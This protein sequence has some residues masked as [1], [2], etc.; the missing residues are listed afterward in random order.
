MPPYFNF[1]PILD[2]SNNRLNTVNN[3]ND[4][5][6]SDKSKH[7]EKIDDINCKFECNKDGKY[8]WRPFQ[9]I[10]P[11]MYINLVN[12][13]TEQDNW[14]LLKKRFR[15]FK[16]NQGHIICCSDLVE[17]NNK[18]KSKVAAILS[19][20]SEFEQQS[21]NLA[22]EFKHL[23]RTDIT[24]C[25]GSIYTHSIAWAVHEKANVKQNMN[26]S[27]YK[28]WLGNKIDK[29]IQKMQ[30]NQTNGIPQGSSLMDF[31]AEIVL[32]YADLLLFQRIEKLSIKYYKILRY[33][34]DYRIFTN[35]S[36][37]AERILGE[38]TKVL[39]ELSLKLNSA[40]TF[41]SEDIITDSIKEDK[42][43]W[44]QKKENFTN[45]KLQ[46]KI[47]IIRE[48]G[49][50]YPNSGSLVKALTLLYQN[51]I[52]KLGNTPHNLIQM[53]SIVTDIMYLNPRTYPICS[54]ILSKLLEHKSNVKKII[55]KIFNKMSTLPNTVYFE[56]WFQRMCLPK[57]IMFGNVTKS[58]LFEK[59][60]NPI[61]INIWNSEW[62]NITFDE[63][64]II[65]KSTIKNL[66]IIILVDEV[67]VFQNYNN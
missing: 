44:M 14:K 52:L 1:Q 63:S 9:I 17:S 62:L 61:K 60:N 13:I 53:I 66:P 47:L 16:N 38:L 29:S 43:Y 28:D 32:G 41:L 31:I 5:Y 27:T 48:L 45:L 3:L 10:H 7:P 2:W 46:E 57:K 50:K 54:A 65:D 20:W 37:T 8:A 42:M 19:W 24:D 55:E 40:K 22:L 33:R 58:K 35:D 25:Y 64:I 18:K 51:Y 59:V 15:E 23:T 39:L 26:A 34:D 67:N 12:I 49:K 36:Q 6:N 30:Y 4:L 56:V 21:I 11:L